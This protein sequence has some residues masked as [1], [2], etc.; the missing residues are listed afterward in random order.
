MSKPKCVLLKKL[1]R[2]HSSLYI[3]CDEVTTLQSNGVKPKFR[4]FI[5]VDYD[6]V[7]ITVSNL[8]RRAVKLEGLA[9][10]HFDR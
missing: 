5:N 10:D 1:I 9:S 4:L 3:R 2:D 8:H 6:N 7:T